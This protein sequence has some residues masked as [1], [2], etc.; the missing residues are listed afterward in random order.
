M[1][2]FHGIYIENCSNGQKLDVQWKCFMND[3]MMLP[4]VAHNDWGLARFN[5]HTLTSYTYYLNKKSAWVSYFVR[6]NDIKTGITG[7]KKYNSYQQGFGVTWTSFQHKNNN[8]KKNEF[9]G[10]VYM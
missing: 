1:F 9:W 3:K 5:E 7:S 10:F 4:P 6:T 8:F 2:T